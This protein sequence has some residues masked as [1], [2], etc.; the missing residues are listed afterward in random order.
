MAEAES[1]AMRGLKEELMQDG[2]TDVSD[3]DAE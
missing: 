2:D 3:G 1:E